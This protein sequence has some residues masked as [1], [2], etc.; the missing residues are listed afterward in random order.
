MT[1][2]MTT[3]ERDVS[4]YLTDAEK[5]ELM[6]EW[7]ARCA[8]GRF[9]M[10]NEGGMGF[11]DAEM[12]PWNAQ[13]NAIPGIATYQSCAGHDN[14]TEHVCRGQ[15]WLRMSER[16][17]QV[18]YLRAFELHARGDLIERV[19]TLFGDWGQEIADIQFKGCESELL[20]ESMTFIIDFLRGLTSSPP[21]V[22][23]ESDEEVGANG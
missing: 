2:V 11:P 20:G 6:R 3:R 23:D 19:T 5:T 7:S 16:V 21:L 15:L 10:A 1:D 18:F 14:G 13:I 9:T 22:P 8:V 4:R 17:A 12:I